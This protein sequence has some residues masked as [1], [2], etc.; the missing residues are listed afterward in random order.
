MF[1]PVS[2]IQDAMPRLIA[3]IATRYEYLKMREKVYFR[4][5]V[6]R[7]PKCYGE[8]LSVAANYC[9]IHWSDRA[10]LLKFNPLV[11][12]L[13][14]DVLPRSRKSWFGNVKFQRVGLPLTAS[15]KACWW[16]KT[17]E[18]AVKFTYYRTESS[19]TVQKEDRCVLTASHFSL[20]KQNPVSGRTRHTSP[21]AK[22]FQASDIQQEQIRECFNVSMGG[23]TMAWR[24]ILR[25]RH[26]Q[27]ASF[28]IFCY[29]KSLLSCAKSWPQSFLVSDGT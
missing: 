13:Y 29:H 26:R 10:T 21:V 4:R 11:K 18:T 27:K 20:Y 17:Q 22:L 3:F 23:T 9:R 12:V 16:W 28:Q 8:N 14:K 15:R 19:E 2:E 1:G 6:W 24:S 5:F 7:H 25:H